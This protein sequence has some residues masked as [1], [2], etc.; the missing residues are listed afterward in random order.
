MLHARFFDLKYGCPAMIEVYNRFK[1]LKGTLVG[2]K[3][4]ACTCSIA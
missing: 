4:K 2:A 3:R 1:F